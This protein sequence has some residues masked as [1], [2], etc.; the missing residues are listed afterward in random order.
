MIRNCWFKEFKLFYVH[1]RSDLIALTINL[2][3]KCIV[4]NTLIKLNTVK[5]V[6]SKTSLSLRGSDTPILTVPIKTR[7]R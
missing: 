7:S 2:T 5:L 1:H 4:L 6:R 3:I